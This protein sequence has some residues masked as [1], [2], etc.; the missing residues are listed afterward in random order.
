MY[1]KGH[2]TLK[3]HHGMQWSEINQVATSYVAAIIDFLD[4]NSAITWV[5]VQVE[6]SLEASL[7]FSS[8]IMFAYFSLRVLRILKILD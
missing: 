1:E 2:R 6:K 8:R 3:F 5:E 4:V 7:I